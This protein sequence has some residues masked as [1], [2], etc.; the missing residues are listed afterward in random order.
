[1]NIPHL[2]R[3][4]HGVPQIRGLKIQLLLKR[5][6]VVESRQFVS[7]HAA[8]FVPPQLHQANLG[9]NAGLRG[10]QKP[11]SIEREHKET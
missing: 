5:E 2:R 3:I 7:K 11:L 8:T 9:G 6:L 10:M 4:K 1:M